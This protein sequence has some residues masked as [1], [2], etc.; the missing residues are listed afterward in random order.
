M[1]SRFIISGMYYLCLFLSAEMHAV[2]NPIL[3]NLYQMDTYQKNIE[4]LCDVSEGTPLPVDAARGGHMGAV[5]DGKVFVAGGTSWSKDKTTKTFLANSFIFESGNWV[6]GSPLPVPLAYFMYDY[7]ETGLFVAGGT[8]DGSTMSTD[9]YML[10]TVDK[11]GVW[12][13]LCSLPE[14][15]S[16]G[17]GAI[18]GDKFYVAGGDTGEGYTNKM[19]MLDISGCDGTWVE[20]APMPGDARMLPSLTACGKYLYLLGGLANVSPL[21]PLSD[22]FRYDPEKNEWTR[23]KDL[24]F[25]G[26]A[27]ASK[28]IDDVNILITGR[29]DG[30]IHKGIWIL[31]MQDLSVTEIGGLIIQTATAP[32]VRVSDDTLWIIGGEPDANK[33]RTEKVSI[34]KIKK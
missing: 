2:N 13:K 22:L 19:W 21:M 26:Y 5:I 6:E 23:L 30:T 16:Y 9:V 4:I 25:K 20:C 1:R 12:K 18:S 33:T 14:G 10:R 32:L 27:W 15:V 17:A 11:N 28:A 31:N 24:S 7:N 8:T 3:L 34:I 29:A